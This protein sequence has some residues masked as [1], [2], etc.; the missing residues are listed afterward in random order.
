MPNC[1]YNNNRE[2]SDHRLA[3]LLSRRSFNFC[4]KSTNKILYIIETYTNTKCVNIY[5]EIKN[6]KNK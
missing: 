2:F 5:S 6:L 4:V 1:P 3:S